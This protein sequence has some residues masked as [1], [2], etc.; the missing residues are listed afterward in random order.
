MSQG[1]IKNLERRVDGLGLSATLEINERSNALL[2][3]GKTVYKLGL[4]QSPFPV[5][6]S[7]VNQLRLHASEKDYLPVRGLA[8]LREAVAAHQTR[9]CGLE[10]Q[11]RDVLIG[12]GSKELL[13]LLQLVYDAQL[14]LPNPS[15]VSYEPQARIAG[16]DVLWV[17][18]DRDDMW[19]I[20]PDALAA[21]VAPEPG[22]AR[23]LLLNYPSN[24]TG[25]TYSRDHLKAIARVARE[26]RMLV[27]SDEIYGELHH[28]GDH[29]SIASYYPEGTLV[30]GG[31][32]KWCGAG[33]WR[34]GTFLF[35]PQLR[36][37]G[38]AMAAA[39][40][41]TF[42][43]TSAPIQYAA[44]EAFQGN[45]EIERYLT[46]SRA[47]VRDLGRWIASELRGAGVS[48]D[49]PEGGFYLFPDFE[50]LAESLDRR[51]I[52]SSAELTHRC[53]EE[54]GVAFLP[55]SCFGRPPEERTARIAYVNFDGAQALAEASE[56]GDEHAG[57]LANLPAC[58]GTRDAVRRLTDWLRA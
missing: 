29:V 47:I 41:E 3:Q 52:G 28:L 14:V 8:P 27:L 4:G 24:P 57:D 7:V 15:W 5:P 1:P 49:D 11:A 25:A 39:A 19:R 32:S 54:A 53:L 12:P 21:A 26:H 31:L 35:P 45:P 30:S 58:E 44:I 36:W 23:I 50:P 43:S 51:Q 33:G 37:L 17:D 34:L 46:L 38:D 10:A 40:S 55:G 13:F 9:V 16:R 2:A 48:V 22:R 42:T 20:Q 6:E 18:S 56:R